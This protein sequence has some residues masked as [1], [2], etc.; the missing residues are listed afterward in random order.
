MYDSHTHTVNSPDGL[1]TIDEL[2]LTAIEKGVKGV[3]VTEHTHLSPVYLHYFPDF[4]PLPAIRQGIK[5]VLYGQ[6]KYGDRLLLTCGLEIDEYFDDPKGNDELISLYDFDVLLG[7]IHYL[8]EG[9]WNLQYSKVVY[10]DTVSDQELK[11]YL[12]AYFEAIAI[13]A[14]RT[15]IDVLAHLT[16]PMRYINGRH[17]RGLDISEFT[18]IIKDILTTIISRK[19]ALE[20]N[21]TGLLRC[22]LGGCLCPDK[23]LIT[24]YKE[25]GGTLITL[26]SDAHRTQG[27]AQAFKETKDILKKLGFNKYHFYKN[28]KPMDIS[29]D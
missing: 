2:C 7:S 6:E 17:S 5:D 1:Q 27:I 14:E 4:K 18:P 21:T 20:I 8:K 16:C 22:E 12:K 13:M 23:D 3:A 10:D 25:L 28:R 9:K 26:G 24:L 11:D 29:I 15:D 19:I